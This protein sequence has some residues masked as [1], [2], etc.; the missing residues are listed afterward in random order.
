MKLYIRIDGDPVPAARPRASARIVG[1]RALVH[2]YTPKETEAFEQRVAMCARRALQAKPAWRAISLDEKVKFRTHIHFVC[3]KE[4]FDGDNAEKAV[5]D[6]LTKAGH[7]RVDAPTGKR[8]KPKR[9]FLGGVYRDDRRVRG[10]LWSVEVDPALAPYTEVLVEVA[11]ILDKPLWMAVAL[12]QGWAPPA[13]KE[14][15]HG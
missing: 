14:A 3:A 12:E 10:G 2:V 11:T 13:P 1:G 4:N 6:G 8:K 15:D 9:I 5:L 7:F